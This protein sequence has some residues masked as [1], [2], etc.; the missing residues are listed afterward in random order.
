MNELCKSYGTQ[1]SIIRELF[2]YGKKRKSEIGEENVFDFTLGNPS[3]L[4]PKIVNDTLIEIISKQS[5]NNSLHGYTSAMGD[6][7]VRKVI[8]ENLTK[9]T[10]VEF[11]YDGV[12]MTC[13]AASSL[14]IVLRGLVEKKTTEVVVFA[15][16]FPEYR[17]FIENTGA[18]CIPVDCDENFDIDFDSLD[19]VFNFHT[20]VLIINSPN[21]P[22]GKVYSSET[23]KKLGEY[24][25][26]KEKEYGHYIYLISDEPYREIVYLDKL[27]L[28]VN[29]YNNTIICYS[30][31]KSLS[32]AGERIGYIAIPD[33][34]YNR[35]Y[36][37][38]KGFCGAA[39][40]LGY[41]NAPTL[42]QQLIGKI[43]GVISNIEE[44]RKNRDF[45][46]NSLKNIG[47]NVN[48]PDGAF[49]LLVK[50]LEDDEEIFS[51]IAKEY[52]LLLVPSTSFGIKGYV[53]VS[54]C[55]PYCQIK[56]SLPA[57][58]KLFDRYKES[59]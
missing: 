23:L 18:K 27:P 21:N 55:V 20:R 9:K 49:Y 17:T 28:P 43:D 24:L 59:K 7:G 32:L 45:L 56:N 33:K 3:A 57:F 30:Y 54:Y 53:R 12:F 42:F 2:E 1:P 19:K 25:R 41:V 50:A 35:T 44:Y 36:Y 46:C 34:M 29:Y 52:E 11:T 47:Y 40:L 5:N 16:Y 4:P 8:A 38:M 15:P 31:S 37:M 14:S 10:G 22:S 39:R 26:K 6:I 13:G 58:Q 48:L 51:N